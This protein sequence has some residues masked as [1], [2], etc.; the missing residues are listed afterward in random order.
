MSSYSWAQFPYDNLCANPTP[1]TGFA[2]QSFQNAML[3]DGTLLDITVATD[4]DFLFCDQSWRGFSGFVFPPTS[5][6]Q[7]TLKWMTSGQA[8]LTDIYGWSGVALLI[9]IIGG[10]FGGSALTFMLGFVK[11]TY[12]P[13]GKNAHIDFHSVAEISAY[14]PQ[15][16]I[17]AF[18]YPVLACNV[19]NFVKTWIGWTDP[20]S[21]SYDFHNLIFD[22]PYEGMREKTERGVDYQNEEEVDDAAGAVEV[23]LR[24]RPIYSIVKSWEIKIRSNPVS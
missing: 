13:S 15:F 9:M 3:N 21:P 4:A 24:P 20:S 16:K 8:N 14:V 22:V 6:K 5:S 12:Q 1:Q 10:I 23:S 19:D 17:G 11:G 18:Q 2:G 7:G